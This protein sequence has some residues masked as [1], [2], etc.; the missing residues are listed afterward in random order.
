MLVYA[1]HFQ[2]KHTY[3]LETYYLETCYLETLRDFDWKKCI[4]YV[5]HVSVAV[6]MVPSLARAVSRW[7]SGP[8]YTITLDSCVVSHRPPIHRWL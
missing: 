6:L 3:Y 4:A 5:L 8:K 2:R 1:Q 7:F